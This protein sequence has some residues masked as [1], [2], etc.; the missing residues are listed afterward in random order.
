MIFSIKIT[1]E[2]G[3]VIEIGKDG[4][5]REKSL[6]TDVEVHMDTVNNDARNKS[7]AMLAKIKIVGKINSEIREEVL[8]IFNWS[9]ELDQKKWYRTIEIKAKSSMSEV[10]RTYIIPNVFVVD[11]FENYKTEMEG[12]NEADQ[13]ELYLT[14]QENN[15]KTIEAF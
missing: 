6:I 7:N 8:N 3:E 2:D 10:F 5:E 1:S 15:F 13:F 9:K 11:Y 4:K 12:N 14:Q